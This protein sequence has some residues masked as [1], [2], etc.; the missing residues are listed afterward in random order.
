[1]QRFPVLSS[2]IASVGWDNNVLEI[3]FHDG[4]VYQYF[5]VSYLEYRNFLSSSSLGRELSRLDKRHGYV[6]IR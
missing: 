1:M 6:R 4:S 2:R 3:G 5:G